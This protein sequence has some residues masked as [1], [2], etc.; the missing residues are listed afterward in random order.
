[1]IA[2][3]ER[4]VPPARAARGR[5]AK[6]ERSGR[7]ALLNAP[8]SAFAGLGFESADLRSIAEAAGV[9]QNLIRIHFGSKAA[10]WDACLDEI[11]AASTPTTKQIAELSR[12]S[13][14]PVFERL[15]EAIGWTADFYAAHP[16]VR[17]FIARHTLESRERSDRLT[18]LLLRPAFEAIRPMLEEAVASGVIHSGHPAIIFA[19]INNAVSPPGSFPALIQQ[20]APE[21]DSTQARKHM[22]ETFA[23]T[24]LR[25]PDANGRNVE[26]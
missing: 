23:T 21:I 19:L 5:P 9:S 2:D 20:I 7:H 18:E 3:M 22:A 12:E 10:L 4:A 15:R 26:S 24:L 11:I 17:D 1:M 13:S 8:T 6:G 14:R 16:E 25:E